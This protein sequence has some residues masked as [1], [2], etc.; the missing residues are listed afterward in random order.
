MKKNF[1][2]KKLASAL[3]LALVVASFSPAGISAQAATATKIVKQGGGTAPAVLYVGGSKVDYSLSTIKSGVKYTW[4]SSNTKIATITATT[5]VVTAK[6]PG[7]VTITATATNKKTGKVLNTFKKT[8]T[9]NLRSTSVEAGDDFTLPYGETKKLS[10]VLTPSNSTDV[11]NFV[12]SDKNVAT[13]GLTGGVV[14]AKGAGEATITVYAK[15]TKASANK[16]TKTKVAT[17]KVTVPTGIAKAE[18]TKANTVVTTFSGSVADKTFAPSDFKIVN[19]TTKVVYPVKSVSVDGNKVTLTTYTSMTDG[20]VYSVTYDEKTAQFTATDG[21]VASLAFST[22]TVPYETATAVKVST[23]DA[24]GVVIATHGVST[25]TDSK[26]EF[27]L[28]TVQGYVSG[29]DLV[30]NA[31]GNTATAKAVYHT[32]K[33]DTEGNEVGAITINATITAVDKTA[34][35]LKSYKYTIT[36]SASTPN[37]NTYTA[38]TKV[39]VGDTHYL[40]FAGTKSDDSSVSATDGYTYESTNSDVLLVSTVSGLSAKVIAVQTG[41]AYVLVKDANGNVIYS[42]PVNI[43]A[44]R[45][46]TSIALG[47]TTATV[48]N[49]LNAADTKTVTVTKKDQYNDSMATVAA[50]DITVK[51]LSTP[52]TVTAGTVV[53]GTYFDISNGKVVFN[54]Q[55]ATGVKAEKGTYVYQISVGTLPVRNVTVTIVEPVAGSYESYRLDVTN[56]SLDLVFAD[57]STTSKDVVVK[58]AKLTGGIFDGY[59]TLNSLGA[60]PVTQDTTANDGVVIKL[61]STVVTGAAISADSITFDALTVGATSVTKAAIGNYTIALTN[62]APLNS[63]SIALSLNGG[64]TLTDSQSGAVA[65]RNYT[66]VDVDTTQAELTI[67]TDAVKAAYTFKF[68]GLTVPTNKVTNV[69]YTK[70]GNSIYV[71]TI[72]I[73]VTIDGYEVPV[74]ITVGQYVN[75]Y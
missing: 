71:K 22:V 34:V 63:N 57:S 25:N 35:T 53:D 5:G 67:V 17:V 46:A 62:L 13:V 54:G 27:T 21:V 48:S 11:I 1:F 64:F 24:N 59:A 68:E 28:S 61:G 44:A 49:T 9:V 43:V 58:V 60:A 30:L 45:T 52:S 74:T 32:W 7:S 73:D 56:A 6:A 55:K 75:V 72:T 70:N 37:W 18:Q 40:H 12:S 16:S 15:A 10:A 20:K 39:A 69:T 38:N 51:V 47:A 66:S 36:S 42:L 29:D 19:D 41:S 33:Y 23:V 50:G 4:K 31:I 14:T 2:K 8:L 65:T 3:A 26:L